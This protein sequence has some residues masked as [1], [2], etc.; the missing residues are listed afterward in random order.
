MSLHYA[1]RYYGLIPEMVTITTSV[2]TRHTREFETPEGIYT[3]RQVNT[4]YFPI[5]ITMEQ[6]DGVS[7]LIATP[8][9]ALCDM[10][11]REKYIQGQS[12]AA[13]A[14]FLEEDMR[15][16]ID[17]LKGMNCDIIRQCREAGHKQQIL[18]NLIKLIER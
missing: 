4:K 15:I 3:Y 11:M 14:V 12:L 8:E 5:G 7:Y 18:T 6:A 17:D 10:I 9:K 16:D 1:L 2:T 13:L